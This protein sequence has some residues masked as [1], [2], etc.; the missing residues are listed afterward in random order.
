L[1]FRRPHNW[2]IYT[3]AAFETNGRF[4]FTPIFS[5]TFYKAKYSSYY[6]SMPLPFRF[7]ADKPF[8]FTMGLQLGV[9]F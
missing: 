8:S 2:T 3:R 4:G 1:I 9:T 5:K 7:G 6:L